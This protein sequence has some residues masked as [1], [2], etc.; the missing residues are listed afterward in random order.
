MY[1]KLGK[2]QVFFFN[3]QNNAYHNLQHCLQSFCKSWLSNETVFKCAAVLIWF[4]L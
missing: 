1:A 3:L 4:A 2:F